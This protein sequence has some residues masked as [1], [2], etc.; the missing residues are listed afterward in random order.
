[1]KIGQAYRIRIIT[2]YVTGATVIPGGAAAYD[3]V[4]ITRPP[5]D[6]EGQRQRRPRRCGGRARRERRARK[7]DDQQER[8]ADLRQGSLL[9]EARGRLQDDPPFR[10]RH[11][12]RAEADRSAPRE[13][14]VG[15]EAHRRAA[16]EAEG[17]PLCLTRHVTRTGSSSASRSRRTRSPRPSWSRSSS[18]A[19]FISCAENPAPPRRRRASSFFQGVIRVA[20]PRIGHPKTASAPPVSG[21]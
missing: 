10:P 4:L 8:Q 5:G 3:A 6:R 13:G 20:G 16:G 2:R 7:R 21:R 18:R 1:M 12:A 15:Q 17:L 14:R 9:A 19:Y 11:Q